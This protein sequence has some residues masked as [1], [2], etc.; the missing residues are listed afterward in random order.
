MPILRQDGEL[1]FGDIC[2]PVR[3]L[4]Q[5]ANGFAAM[6][7]EACNVEAGSTGLFRAGE[8]WFEIRLINCIPMDPQELEEDSETDDQ[9]QCFRLGLYR[10]AD[11]SD[12]D[13]KQRGWMWPVFRVQ[14]GNV[15]PGNST[16][17]GF[18]VIFVLFVVVLPLMAIL[19]LQSFKGDKV[20]DSAGLTKSIAATAKRGNTE[21]DWERLSS[22]A[23]SKATS[24]IDPNVDAAPLGRLANYA[25]D[26]L[27]I[28]RSNP[29]ASVF[30]VP[31]V[32]QKLGITETQKDQ[33]K[34]IVEATNDIVN[35]LETQLNRSISTEEYQKLLST[36][37]N[38]AMQLLT[39]D[40]RTKWQI[41]SDEKT[42]KKN[43][44]KI[45]KDK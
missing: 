34:Q 22:T 28:I 38:S 36:A 33:L 10:L 30:M 37:R 3:V 14:Y 19:I 24:I 40:Q 23:Q 44:P 11:I 45:K 21:P 18:G 12:P 27:S 1:R 43:I 8:D 7:W 41:L 31:E 17:L 15:M 5:S 39:D 32:I 29:G 9:M 2:L 26:L 42:A 25:E 16:T 20:G 6:A 35:E 13:V 4:D